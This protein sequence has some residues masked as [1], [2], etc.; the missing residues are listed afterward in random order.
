MS[1]AAAARWTA[2]MIESFIQR[3]T[4]VQRTKL[5]PEIELA[6]AVDPSGIFAA[7][8]RMN[9][10]AEAQSARESH[11]PLWAFAWPGGQALARHVLDHP[12]MVHNR[13]ILDI[14]AGSGIAAIAAMQAGAKDA[15]AADIDHCAA[16]AIRANARLNSVTV[17]TTTQDVLGAPP[18][19]DLI[20]IADLVYE[21]ALATRMAAFLEWAAKDGPPVLLADRTDARR[22]PGS[23][24][25]IAE[26]DAP[27]TPS[28]PELPFDKS[29]LWQLGQPRRDGRKLT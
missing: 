22:P 10:E 21:P 20:M 25:L 11:P 15:L 13:R 19:S 4:R 2:T 8:E 17:Q 1:A 18:E 3:H 9:S 29:R 27:L 12:E 16:A 7:A 24:V 5:V 26:F 28:L 6:L 23:F 14:G